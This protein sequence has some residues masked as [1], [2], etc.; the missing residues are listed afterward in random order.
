MSSLTSL[1]SGGGGGGLIVPG[2]VTDTYWTAA[3]TISC[4]S[5]KYLRI[6]ALIQTSFQTSSTHNIIFT[7]SMGSRTVFSGETLGDY[8]NYWAFGT[9]ATQ[10]LASVGISNGGNPVLPYIDGKVDEDIVISSVTRSGSPQGFLVYA[11]MEDA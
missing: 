8:S 7:L 9:S 1:I 11:V 3:T 2:L 10:G 6:L 4:P 5:G